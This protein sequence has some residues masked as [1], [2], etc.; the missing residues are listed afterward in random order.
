MKNF[1]VRS[2]LSTVTA[3]LLLG[4]G[5]AMAAV[6]AEVTAAMGD[7]KTDSLAVASLALVV[8]V[9]ITAFKYMRR[10]L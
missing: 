6:P 10:A 2:V 8:I 4:A 5:S 3:T 1:T 9:S 7:A